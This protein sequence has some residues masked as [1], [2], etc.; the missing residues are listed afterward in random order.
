MKRFLRYFHSD[1]I[2]YIDDEVNAYARMNDCEIVS[3]TLLD[4]YANPND[5]D[6][7]MVDILV[8][9]EEKER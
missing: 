4:T 6:Q 3:L 5:V 1:D 8:L 9:F 2:R 7:T